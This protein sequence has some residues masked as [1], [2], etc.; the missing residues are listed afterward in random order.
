VVADA[1]KRIPDAEDL[2][3]ARATDPHPRVR[4]EAVRGLSFF[5]TEAAMTAV[6]AAANLE[7]A[8]RYVSYTAD[9]ALGANIAVWKPAWEQGGFAARN[10]PTA[11]ILES[12]LGLDKKA[13]EVRPHLAVLLAEQT[14]SDEER[15][16]A[17][18]AIADITGGNPENGKL[19]FRRVCIN[20][21]KV[22]TEG[23]DLGPD[24]TQVG[25]RLPPYKLVESII[26]PNA[27]VDP[28]YLSTLVVTDD[29]K[30]ITGLLVSETEQELVIF[31]G[32]EQ[33]KISVDSIEERVKLK[34]SSMPEGLAATLSPT[35]FLDVIEYMKGLK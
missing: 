14:K 21:H 11:K 9:A 2:L 35:E 12:V 17:M 30:S 13:G 20:C 22:G 10:T 19:V 23:A 33:K 24:M 25:K 15:N 16:K 3:I 28:K 18:Q 7:P 8:D 1:R 6:A 26:D 5:S 27:E 32:K 4:T 31:D 34:Q 29:G